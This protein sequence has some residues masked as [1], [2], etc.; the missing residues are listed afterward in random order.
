M[1]QD[2]YAAKDQASFES[3][4]AMLTSLDFKNQTEVQKTK[5]LKELEQSAKPDYQAYAQE[6]ATLSV[7][8]YQQRRDQ[9]TMGIPFWRVTKE[10]TLLGYFTSEIC[11]QESF[12][13]VPIPGKLD[14]VK[15]KKGQKLYV[16]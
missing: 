7:L 4:L 15:Y 6:Q 9:Q 3:G 13:F 5:I 10:L 2:C 8:P 16:Y 1:I 12:D 14:L 11:I